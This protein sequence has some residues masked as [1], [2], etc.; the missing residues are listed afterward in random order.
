MPDWGGKVA[1]WFGAVAAVSVALAALVGATAKQPLHGRMRD[2]F[3][4]LVV[5]AAVSFAALLLSGPPALWAAWRNRRRAKLAHPA[6]P[7]K[8]DLATRAEAL[9]RELYDFVAERKRDDPMMKS[10]LRSATGRSVLSDE[11]RQREWAE[12]TGDMHAFSTETMNR[13]RQ[14]F[15]VRVLA[16]YD[17]AVAAG[18]EKPEDRLSFEHPTNELGIERVAQRIG[19]IGHKTRQG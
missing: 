15:A 16:V 17:D 4:A 5:V 6:G 13:Y 18:N 8:P 19:V 1:A 2:L 7:P 3:A 9:S 14:R 10:F 11:E 12:R